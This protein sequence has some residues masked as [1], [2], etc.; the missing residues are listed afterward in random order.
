MYSVMDFCLSIDYV[1]ATDF[2]HVIQSIC[3]LLTNI[4]IY[5]KEAISS[6]SSYELRRLDDSGNDFESLSEYE[7]MDLNLV[8]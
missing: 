3:H 4:A 1:V 5:C 2:C 7:N 8:F 6:C